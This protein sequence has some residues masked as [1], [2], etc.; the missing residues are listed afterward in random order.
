M[1]PKFQE[2]GKYKIDE[3]LF[4]K[5]IRNLDRALVILQ[6]NR[7]NNHVK[8]EVEEELEQQ[9]FTARL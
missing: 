2:E 3:A 6:D 5:G 4:S 1:S 9:N 7:S 8:E